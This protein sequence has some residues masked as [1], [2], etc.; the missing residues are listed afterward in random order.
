MSNVEIELLVLNSTTWNSSAV[1]LNW[2]I[3]MT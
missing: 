1:W 3:G 2:I